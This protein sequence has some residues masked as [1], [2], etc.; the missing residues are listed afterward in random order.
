MY[1]VKTDKW[2][3]PIENNART[4]S[5]AQIA[6]INALIREFGST[7]PILTDGDAGVD[8]LAMAA[9]AGSEAWP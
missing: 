1:L 2:R 3:L 4:H 8:P 9:T 6:K 7:N 5:D